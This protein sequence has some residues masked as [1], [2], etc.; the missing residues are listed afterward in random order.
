MSKNDKLK[1]Q[2]SNALK[3]RMI[4]IEDLVSKVRNIHKKVKNDHIAAM[5]HLRRISKVSRK[6]K[7]LK[8]SF[9]ANYKRR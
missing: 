1:Q 7:R 6:T 2:F 4:S 5:S 3:Q 9:N 8:Q